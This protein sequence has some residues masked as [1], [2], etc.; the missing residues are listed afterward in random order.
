MLSGITIATGGLGKSGIVAAVLKPVI[1]VNLVARP[2]L[3]LVIEA[4]KEE[5]NGAKYT[6]ARLVTKGKQDWKYGR[7]E[8]KAK[9]KI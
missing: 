3:I 9:M 7:F 6:S 5:Y 2:V 8:I 4:I 1:V